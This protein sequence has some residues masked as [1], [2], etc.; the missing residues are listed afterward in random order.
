MSDFV[1]GDSDA[2]DFVGCLAKRTGWLK[3]MWKGWQVLDDLNDDLGLN[4][5]TFFSTGSKKHFEWL[6]FSRCPTSKSE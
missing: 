3:M 4:P 2:K 1:D 5:E 6:G